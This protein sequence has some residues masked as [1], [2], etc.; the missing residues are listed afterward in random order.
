MNPSHIHNTKRNL[1]QVHSND[2]YLPKEVKYL[3]L[4]LDRRLTWRKH[5]FTKW[6]QLGMTITKTHWLL[7][8]K[9]KV[10][11]SNKSIIYK[12]IL[13]SIWTH[14][15][16]LWGT[17]SAW[18]IEIL[19]CFQSKAL[20]IILDAPCYV[21]NTVIWTDLQTPTVK[22]YICQYS[23]HYGARLSVHPDNL[24]VNLMVQPNNNRQLWRHLPDDLP[25]RFIV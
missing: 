16:Q 1:P 8:R 6:K 20:S 14:G 18:N 22:K 11:T 2:V 4:H 19:E 12:A 25:T 9:S 13:K 15:I 24:V 17:A 21:P 10:S 23:F 7:K 5:I 3:G